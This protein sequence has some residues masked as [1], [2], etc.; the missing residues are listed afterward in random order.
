[1]IFVVLTAAAVGGGGGGGGDVD[2][3]SCLLGCDAVSLGEPFRRPK[4]KLYLDN[5]NVRKDH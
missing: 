4:K 1:M 3:D 2:D 5:V